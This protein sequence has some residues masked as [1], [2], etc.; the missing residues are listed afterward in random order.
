MEIKRST[1]ELED[2]HVMQ[3][4]GSNGIVHNME[5]MSQAYLRNQYSSEID[6]HEEFVSSYPHEDAPLPIFLKFEDVEYKVRNIQASLKTMVSKVV[7]HTNS[8]PDGYKHILKGITGST[9]PGEILALMGPSGSGKTTLL[10]IMG[11]RLTDNVKG[12]LTY[13]DIPY[14]PSVKR[15]IGFVTQDDV[16]LPQLTVE[17]TLAFAA[18]LR[19]PSNM[20]KEQK[21]AKV[22]MII[23]ELGLERCRHTRV[24][25]GFVKGIS[26]GERK[27]TSIAYEILVDPSLLLLDEPTSGLDSTSA[28]KLLHI[29]QGVAKAGRTVITTIHQPSSRM[30]HMFDK[31]L[32]ISEGHPAYYGKARE[33]MEYFSSLRILPEIAMNPAEFLLDL[34]TGQVSDISLPEELLATKT[35]QPDSE[36]VIVKYL[37]LRYKT[38]LE[39]K[40]KEE[41]HRNRKAPE[42][43]QIAIQV[44][45][46]WTLSWWDQFMIIFR[47]TFRERR[48]DYFDM[49]RLVQSLGV[50]VVLVYVF[51]F[52]KIYL[53]KER[54]A[55]MY[56]LSVTV[57][58]FVFTVLTILLIAITSQGA[59][60]FLGASVLS[61]KR[62]GMIASLVLMMFLLTGGYYVQH[63]PKFMQWLK[64]LSFMHYGFRLLLK[65]QY[66]ADQVFDCASKGGCRTLQSSSSFDTVNLNGGLEELWVLLA[67]AF[68]YRLCTYVCLRKKISI[69]HL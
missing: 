32:L 11:G 65:V 61:I 66:S 42:H 37:Q 1:E 59:G 25:G 4:S 9:G 31:L 20:S 30:F 67:M 48:R 22:E 45:K 57:P 43:L 64:Y 58:C 29:L 5:F 28:T 24:G 44:K 18:F 51:P 49:L 35:T 62:A 15:R 14:S 46:D 17:E 34:A 40:E 36:N 2:N 63:I 56:R 38:D 19:L 12:K 47:R 23:K 53:V 26:G 52:E 3:I 54:K 39:P 69:C 13:N 60:E 21:Y 27:R 33:A 68:G 7:T 55:D 16:L 6:I 41:N 8:D 50:A 10:K